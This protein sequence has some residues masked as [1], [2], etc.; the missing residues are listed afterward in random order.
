MGKP[1]RELIE[2]A[3]NPAETAASQILLIPFISATLIYLNRKSI[4]QNVRYSLLAGSIVITLGFIVLVGSRVLGVRVAED[5]RLALVTSAI[6]ILW[7]GGFLL[8]YGAEVF[9]RALFPLL[10]LILCVPIPSPFLDRTIP[11]LQR[12]SAETAVVLLKLTGTPVYREGVVLAMPGLIIDVAPECSGIRSSI[13]V[14][15]LS[16]LAGYF[17]LRSWWRRLFLVT[18]AIPI[19]ILKN[20]IRIDTL[21]LLTIHVDRNILQSRLHEEGGFVFFFL[22]LLLLYPILRL[23]VRSERKKENVIHQPPVCEN[24]SLIY[25]RTNV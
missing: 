3:S 5:D 14:I 8:F 1:V 22:G 12:G 10:F 6:V 25:S 2:F 13:G 23:L 16:L 7:L 21:S 4:F 17:L 9:K 20:A 18:A 19:V 15:I 24:T 11:A